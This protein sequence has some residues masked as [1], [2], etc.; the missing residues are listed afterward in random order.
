MKA[1]IDVVQ[2]NVISLVNKGS[3]HNDVNGKY[4]TKQLNSVTER[5]F[6]KKPEIL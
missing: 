5:D 4:D 6:S 3:N 2:V 1:S